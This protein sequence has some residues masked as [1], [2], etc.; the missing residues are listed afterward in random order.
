MSYETMTLPEMQGVLLKARNSLDAA[1][2]GGAMRSVPLVKETV[3]TCADEM[4]KVINAMQ[5]TQQDEANATVARY[6][7]TKLIWDALQQMSDN[8][9]E[10]VDGEPI[11]SPVLDALLEKFDAMF[12]APADANSKEA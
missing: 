11:P 9:V 1:I 7:E 2:N 10:D 3:A 6:Q 12:A 8:R 5:Q 4:S